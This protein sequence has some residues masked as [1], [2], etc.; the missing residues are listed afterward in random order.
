MTNAKSILKPIFYGLMFYLIVPLIVSIY[1]AY[2][3]ERILSVLYTGPIDPNNNII[4]DMGLDYNVYQSLPAFLAAFKSNPYQILAT[5]YISSV[6]LATI[7]IRYIIALG[8]LG[9]SIN[10]ILKT[11]DMVAFFGFILL[12]VGQISINIM[13][14]VLAKI[15][16]GYEGD[17]DSIVWRFLI[18]LFSYLPVSLLTAYLYL[19]GNPSVP[20]VFWQIAIITP[21]TWS[22]VWFSLPKRTKGG[23]F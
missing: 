4:S 2:I 13:P 21:I 22:I 9:S 16:P 14:F 19:Q 1:T 12:L 5:I 6:Q 17:V 20:I 23:D 8:F 7:T 15:K 18:P 3:M 11:K 10:M